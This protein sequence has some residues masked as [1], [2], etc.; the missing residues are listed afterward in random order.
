MD[1]DTPKGDAEA[2]DVSNGS[3]LSGLRVRI[4]RTPHCLH[5][6]TATVKGKGTYGWGNTPSE[7]KQRLAKNL[8]HET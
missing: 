1:T 4:R 3:V 6:Y 7:A 5:A 8:S 2:L